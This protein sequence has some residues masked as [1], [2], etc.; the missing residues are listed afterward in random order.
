[1]RDG[2]SFYITHSDVEGFN[3]LS[4]IRAS[5]WKF[6]QC[7]IWLKHAFVFGRKDYHSR[8][9]PI[10][11]GWKEGAAHHA[12]EDRT[13]DTI[14]EYPRPS[15]TDNAHPT[16]KPIELVE[17][18]IRNSSNDGE[19]VLDLFLGSGTTAIASERTGRACRGIE[20]DPR[21]VALTLERLSLMGLKPHLLA[22]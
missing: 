19:T 1:M 18:S 10:L 2:A 8:H 13:Q 22:P 14:W 15:P 7:V 12:V 4:A 9:E 16:V 20:I 6:S 11:Y 17:R 21:F 5:G 3:F